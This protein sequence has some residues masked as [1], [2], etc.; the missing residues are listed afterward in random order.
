VNPFLRVDRLAAAL[1]GAPASGR[2]AFVALRRL[3]DTGSG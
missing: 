2:D 1:P 3:R